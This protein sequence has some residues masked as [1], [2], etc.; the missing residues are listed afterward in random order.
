MRKLIVLLAL[1]AMACGVQ[2]QLTQA[3]ESVV[4]DYQA[5]SPSAAPAPDGG[6]W[7]TVTAMET[8][9]I[10]PSAGTGEEPIGAL[11]NGQAVF[12]TVIE[13]IGDSFWCRHLQGWTNCRYLAANE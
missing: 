1:S 9:Y 5:P 4:T 11:K 3:A 13:V 2:T 6:Q 12:V 10:R 7:M 8:V